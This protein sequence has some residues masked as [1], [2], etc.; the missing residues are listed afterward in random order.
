MSETAADKD[1]FIRVTFPTGATF[2][3]RP[4][5]SGIVFDAAGQ[6]IDDELA[7]DMLTIKSIK[8]LRLTALGSA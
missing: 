7:A 6:Y 8:L 3:I 4:E 2:S 1:A 5:C